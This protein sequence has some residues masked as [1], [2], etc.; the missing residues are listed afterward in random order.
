MMTSGPKRGI[1]DAGARILEAAMARPDF[2]EGVRTLLSGI[3]PDNSARLA[4]VI[5]SK[6]I[7]LPL[8]LLS[9]LPGMAN[10]VIRVVD[11]LVR[12][13]REAF[14]APLLQG[15]AESLLS[16]IDYEA[17]ARAIENVQG[18]GRDLSPVL[19]GALMALAQKMAAQA[20]EKHDE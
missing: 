14:P 8:S 12:Q 11:E 10:I 4:R 20:G 16:E 9:A 18:L 5:L 7:E 1:V 13:V 6:D 2:K 3:D 15:F 17:L 19:A